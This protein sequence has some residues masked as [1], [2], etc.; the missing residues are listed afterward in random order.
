[1]KDNWDNLKDD[2]KEMNEEEKTAKMEELNEKI[3]DAKPI[4]E[5]LYDEDG[6]LD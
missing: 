2:I 3:P 6:D 4:I 5:I 1:M